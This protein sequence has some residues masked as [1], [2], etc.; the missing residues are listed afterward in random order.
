MSQQSSFGV[1]ESRL[2]ITHY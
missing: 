2:S 1:D